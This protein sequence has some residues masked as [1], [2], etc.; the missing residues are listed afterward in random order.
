MERVRASLWVGVAVV[1]AGVGVTQAAVI[2]AINTDQADFSY[3]DH[4]L[5]ID[6]SSVILSVVRDTGP[7]LFLNSTIQIDGFLVTDESAGGLVA[8]PFSKGGL[9]LQDSGA[10]T[11][12]TGNNVEFRIQEAAIETSPGVTTNVITMAGTFDV[13]GG[14]LLPD[15]PPGGTIASLEV[16]LYGL[17]SDPSS[18]TTDSFDGR[19]KVK[20]RIDPIPEPGT[21]VLLG[22]AAVPLIGRRRRSA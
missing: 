18:L 11:L 16:V 7:T 14:T 10:A 15:F 21:L 12:L 2:K 17:S 20:V 8:G 3:A 19:A 4:K 13:T 5:A 1:L 6:D 9:L 22:A